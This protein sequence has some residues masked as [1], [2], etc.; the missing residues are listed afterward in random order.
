MWWQAKSLGPSATIAEESLWTISYGRTGFLLVQHKPCY[1]TLCSAQRT[2][3]QGP[4]SEDNR[5]GG[6]GAEPGCLPET[7]RHAQRTCCTCRVLRPPAAD[8]LPLPRSA[9]NPPSSWKQSIDLEHM[10]GHTV[11]AICKLRMHPRCSRWTEGNRLKIWLPAALHVPL[12]Q[13]SSCR[14]AGHRDA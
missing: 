9:D 1:T 14:P 2:L 8:R 10:Q 6:I 11:G 13:S 4:L 12:N 7:T 5:V 3:Q